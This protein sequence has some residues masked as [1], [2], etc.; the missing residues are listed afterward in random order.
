ML[1]TGLA[2]KNFIK[3]S[4]SGDGYIYLNEKTTTAIHYEKLTEDVLIPLI[5]Y[6]F[7]SI[8]N[9][10]HNGCVYSFKT[11]YLEMFKNLQKQHSILEI[12]KRI[13]IRANE[14]YN[15]M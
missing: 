9:L 4:S 11:L 15:Q 8:D 10:K 13:I 7:D 5:I 14:I 12:H 3:Y 2:L 6:W 1:L